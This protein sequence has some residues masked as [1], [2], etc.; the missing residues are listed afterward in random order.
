MKVQSP[1]PGSALPPQRPPVILVLLDGALRPPYSRLTHSLPPE[2]FP[3]PTLVMSVPI[4]PPVAS[5]KE[6]KSFDLPSSP[7]YSPPALFTL[8]QAQ[9]TSCDIRSQTRRRQNLNHPG[10]SLEEPGKHTPSGL[11]VHSPEKDSLSN[12][13][14]RNSCGNAHSQHPHATGGA[15]SP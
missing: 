9:R 5:K 12:E 10:R 2:N 1:S 8:L 13:Y 11:G 3:R 14:S 6:Q 7:I 15:P 4:Q